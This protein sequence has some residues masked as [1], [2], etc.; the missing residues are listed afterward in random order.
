MERP[1]WSS[2]DSWVYAYTAASGSSTVNGTLKMD[3]VARETISVN[4]TSYPTYHVAA[5]LTLP[6]GS[7]S[8]TLPSDLWFSTD[9]LAIVKV[10]ATVNFSFGSVSSRSTIEISGNP[11]QTIHWPLAT[12]DAWSS[13]AVVWAVVVAQNGTRTTSSESL[14]TD[15]LVLTDATVTVPAG[16]FMTTPVKGTNRANGSYAVNYWSDQVGH[17]A[18][19]GFYNASGGKS[20]GLALTSYR[21]QGGGFFGIS[22]LGVPVY[23]WLIVVAVVVAILAYAVL[24][25]R[26]PPVAMPPPEM[27]PSPPPESPP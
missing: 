8:F 22:L 20:S 23:L 15:F 19:V 17:W 2:G 7:F 11:P 1:S 25:R 21:Y 6:F 18:Q 14:T 16:S 9:T 3:V 26:R 24:R 5:T 4:G 12:G 10:T 13:S 27:P